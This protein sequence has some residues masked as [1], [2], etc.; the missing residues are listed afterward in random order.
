[1]QTSTFLTVL[2]AIY[3]T[4]SPVLAKGIDVYFITG[5]SNAGNVGEQNGVGATDVGFNLTYGRIMDQSTDNN[6]SSAPTNVVDAYSTNMLDM[7]DAV[8]QLAKAL[9][10]GSG[11]GNDIAIY[12][13]AR[14]G[15]SLG[16]AHAT[17][18]TW[19]P[20]SKADGH[21][22]GS[23]YGEFQAWSAQRLAD[24][25]SSNPSSAVDVK[26]VFWFQGEKDAQTQSFRDAY[27]ANYEYLIGRFRE[28]FGNDITVVGTK[29]RELSSATSNSNAQVIRDA[30]QAVANQDP[31]VS[32]VETT[33]NADGTGGALGNRFGSTAAAFG[34]DVHFSNDAQEVIVQRWA[35]ES[36]AIQQTMTPEPSS[37]IFLG[38]EGLL[39]ARRR[40]A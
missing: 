17:E 13:F 28:D 26:G 6:G 24:L 19:Y 38:L 25:A 8:N 15:R 16:D 39:L 12:T 20:G 18:E 27:L 37:L 5:Q 29:L 9:Y 7:G 1:M 34:S 35:K 2:L 21:F 4:G 3:L 31:W 36:L 30:I 23:L 22:D 33:V 11:T 10:D 14:N 40:L 32:V